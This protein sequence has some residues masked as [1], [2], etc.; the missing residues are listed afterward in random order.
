MKVD[1]MIMELPYAEPRHLLGQFKSYARTRLIF[2]TREIMLRVVTSLTLLISS[3]AAEAQDKP[4][5]TTPPPFVGGSA[6]PPTDLPSGIGS[7]CIYENLVYSIGSPL[8]IGKSGYI[9]A[10]KTPEGD[11]DQ[12]AYWTGR[13]VDPRLSAPVCE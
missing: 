12:R 10:P 9:C 11:F 5:S 7:Y 1:K 3:H 6:I 8:C 2:V 13:P 4:P